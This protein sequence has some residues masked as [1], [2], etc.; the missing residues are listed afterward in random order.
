MEDISVLDDEGKE[1]EFQLVPITD[2]FLRLRS[3]HATA[4]LGNTV[5]DAPK[6]WLVFS[7]SVPP[8]GF[9]TYFITAAKGAGSIMTFCFIFSV[10]TFI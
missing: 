7:V 2:A 9:S 10:L 4:Y 8:L 1:V 3:Y 6:Y 5:N